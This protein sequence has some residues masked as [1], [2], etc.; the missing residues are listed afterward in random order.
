MSFQ[1]FVTERLA[2][3]TAQ[4]NAFIQNAK[5]IDELPK[6]VTLDPNSRFHVSRG[7]LSEYLEVRGIIDAI[8]NNTYNQLVSIGEITLV[9]NEV[10]VPSGAEWQINSVFYNTFTD[11]VITIPYAATGLTRKDI[12]AANTLGQ[13]VRV[14]GA[15][16]AGLAVRPN[17]PIDTIL[18]TEIDASELVIGEPEQPVTL[19][20]LATKTDKGGFPGTSQDLNQRIGVLESIQSL[21]TNFTGKAYA[22]WT[23]FGLVFDVI[24][25]DYYIQGILYPG[26]TEQL[27]LIPS[28]PTDPRL[29]TIAVDST[30]A[31]QINGDAAPNP[32]FPTI[33]PETQIYITTVLIDAGAV[34]PTGVSSENVYLENTEWTA[35]SN[36]GTV[37]FNAIATPFQGTKHIDCGVFTNGQYLRFTDSVINQ[38]ADYTLL[39]FYINLKA[40]FSNSS[41]FSVKFYNGTTLISSVVTIS[42]GTYGFDR[43]AINTY[44]TI[45]L[46]LADFTFTNSSFDRIEIVMVGANATGFRID[47]ISLAQGA[48]SSSPDQKAITSIITDNS[49][50]NATQKDDTIQLI[51]GLGIDITS[52][53]KVITI[54]GTTDLSDYYTKA[55]TLAITDNKV[56]KDGAKVLSDNNYST[57]EKNKLASIDATHYL[58]PLQTTAQLSALPQ[59]TISDKARV[60][61]EDELSDYFY[62]ATASSGD[63][64]PDDQTGGVG[65]WRKVAVGGETAASIKTKYESNPDTNAYTDAEQALVGTISGK[66]AVSNKTDVIAGNEASSSL[67]ASIKGIVDWLTSSKIKSILGITTLSGS[68]T[69][70][71][72]TTA[73]LSN[74]TDKNL[75]TD[76]QLTKVN[77]IDQSVSAAEKATWNAG[78]MTT[79]TDQTVSGVK[80][81]LAGMFGIR[82]AANTFTS[83]FASAVTASR[84]WTWPDK[85]GTVAMVSD[86]SAVATIN[87]VITDSASSRT[88]V[89][90]DAQK[91]VQM[92]YNGGTGSIVVPTNA[93]VPFIIGTTICVY[94]NPGG[95]QNP[96]RN[97][98]ISGSGITFLAANGLATD[99]PT[100]FFLTKVGSDTWL[101]EADVS[102]FKRTGTN[103]LSTS[104]SIN[105]GTLGATTVDAT[106]FGNNGNGTYLQRTT[107]GFNMLNSGS[108][109]TGSANF[110]N[111]VLTWIPTINTNSTYIS[112]KCTPT[113]NQTGTSAGISR[114]YYC[115]PL[116]TSAFDFRALDIQ[117]GSIVLPYLDKSATYIISN[118]DYLI[119]CTSGTFTATLPTA[120]GCAGKTYVLKNSGSGV[121]T[122]S[123][124]SSQTIDGASSYSLSA[125][126]KYVTVV[127]NGANWIITANN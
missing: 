77:A 120:V 9:G 82:N 118:N 99:M 121:I 53:G 101:V 98:T 103:T 62:D 25:P 60:Y 51:G 72:T 79:N 28:N 58:P 12:L 68:N 11:T 1:T 86:I 80:T 114:G 27:T 29:D 15:E 112:Y 61:V 2:T 105:L 30:G 117:K 8:N 75:I 88:L 33:D 6:Q 84:T 50:V 47:N 90:T 123:T 73:G 56:D 124:T 40:V 106:N 48:G 34:T 70:D 26:A 96:G 122:I 36:N 78:D 24:Y 119:D 71:Q 7:G 41:K 59:A 94:W 55:E 13:I 81:F 93:S 100:L 3:I 22:I 5:K 89:I 14:P 44:Q 32:P 4:I 16:S 63:I 46:P 110:F 83:F 67:F 18:V 20:A 45:I 64:A 31:I 57:S 113:I 10:T 111:D 95:V 126:Y 23:G 35:I 127:S 91:V 17:I 125:Q 116:L 109:A 19:E 85:D 21:N 115:N 54:S 97:L 43:N 39:K 37:N 69:G 42:S 104:I 52:V 87:N 65:F 92:T 108:G 66:E 76:A 107:T 38:I 74:T 102:G 49:V